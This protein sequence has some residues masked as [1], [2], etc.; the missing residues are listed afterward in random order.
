M[1][2]CNILILLV[3]FVLVNL[4]CNSL[5]RSAEL[6]QPSRTLGEEP[7]TSGRLTVLSEPPGLNITLNG[8]SLGKTPIFLV[9]IDSGIH[10][11]RVKD[12][13][14]DILVQPG[15]TV[16]ISLHKDEFILIPVKEKPVAE[17]PV[18]EVSTKTRATGAAASRDPVR[19]K[20]ERDRRRSQQRWQQF[21]DGTKPTP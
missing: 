19:E 18:T 20:V 8:D 9:E 21:L 10:T 4:F 16:K 7:Q 15:K 2:V 14:T 1:R 5:A 17:Q 3:V 12:S 6:I 13:E 11:L